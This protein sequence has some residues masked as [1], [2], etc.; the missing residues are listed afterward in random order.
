MCEF[1]V[2]HFVW[3][4]KSFR[5]LCC[6]FHVPE[7]NGYLEHC[8][9]DGDRTVAIEHAREQMAVELEREAWRLMEEEVRRA[10]EEQERRRRV[11]CRLLL[12]FP[13]GCRAYTGDRDADE[14]GGGGGD[15]E[16]DD[17]DGD[18]DCV[19]EECEGC[20]E[21]EDWMWQ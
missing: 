6:N 13:L 18:E 8:E 11:E 15:D 2:E 17:D 9:S 7:L 14:D 5:G 3:V 19:G 16:D 1:C 20:E 12:R 4:R 10:K 21:P